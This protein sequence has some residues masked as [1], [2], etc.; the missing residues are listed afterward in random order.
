[1]IKNI[2]LN[3]F[4][5][6]EKRWYYEYRYLKFKK[7]FKI[8][9]KFGLNENSIVID[10]G[11]NVGDVTKFIYDNYKS[12]IHSY[13]P[14]IHAFN[15]QKVRLGNIDKIFLFN[16]CIDMENSEK[17]IYF[18]KKA[19]EGGDV[20]YSHA[21]SLDPVKSNVSQNNY[22]IV[23]SKSIENILNNFN[24]IDLIKIDI[25]G[26][27]Y[28]IMPILIK[29]KY[30]IKNVICE[31]HGNPAYKNKYKDYEE[32]YLNLIEELNKLNLINKW[33]IEWY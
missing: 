23:K 16:E 17:K 31:L 18:H 28:K 14:N 15:I 3:S 9:D 8:F 4:K 20:E 21:S 29:N 32:K 1:M 19:K 13:E 22:K 25:E 33:F 12:I 27:E 30:K 24:Y 6:K 11:S 7:K 26:Y 5:I 10:L 2:L